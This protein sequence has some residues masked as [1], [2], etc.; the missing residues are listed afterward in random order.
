MFLF[1]IGGKMAG[2]DTSKFGSSSATAVAHITGLSPSE[3]EPVK[4]PATSTYFYFI[5][6]NN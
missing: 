4:K 6:N 2:V 3:W 5:I 1:K